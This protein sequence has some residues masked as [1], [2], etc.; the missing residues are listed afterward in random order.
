YNYDAKEVATTV[1]SAYTNTHEHNKSTLSISPNGE[2]S[3]QSKS[4]KSSS[5]DLEEEEEK[6]SFIDRLE[7]FLNYR[8]SFRYNI[9][10]GK[11]E[12]KATKATLWKPV[13]DFVENSILREILKAK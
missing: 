12:Y 11:M 9:V 5:D 10:T 2:I 7:N 13:T 6:P 8:Y 3:E 1:N 4:V